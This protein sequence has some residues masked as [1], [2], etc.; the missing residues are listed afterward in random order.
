MKAFSKTL[1]LLIVLSL[2]A[3]ALAGCGGDGNNN[4]N[5]SHAGDTPSDRATLTFAAGEWYAQQ[6][7]IAAEA[8]P[9]PPDP[10]L[11]K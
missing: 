8:T 1:I 6:T 3:V 2:L 7:A 10:S 5:N 11:S 9:H 4:S